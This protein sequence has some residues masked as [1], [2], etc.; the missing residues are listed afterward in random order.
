MTDFYCPKCGAPM[1]YREGPYGRFYGCSKYP[2][3]RGTRNISE[4]TQEEL[5]AAYKADK[6]VVADEKFSAL[7][8]AIEN[9]MFFLHVQTDRMT[10]KYGSGGLEQTDGFVWVTNINKKELEYLNIRVVH[11]FNRY[12]SWFHSVPADTL[13]RFPWVDT[14]DESKT[15]HVPTVGYES[16]TF[17]QIMADERLDGFALIELV[18][19]TTVESEKY[20]VRVTHFTK[21][22]VDETLIGENITY[23]AAYRLGYKVIRKELYDEQSK[24]ED[25][26][27]ARRGLE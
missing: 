8:I 21:V 16:I 2:S 17:E 22:Y 5:N 19:R 15:I 14:M 23:A 12:G 9:K 4:F 26:Y 3:C 10:S 24:I 7:K 6:K 20:F 27:L 1:K 25:D 13:T 11:S 18:K